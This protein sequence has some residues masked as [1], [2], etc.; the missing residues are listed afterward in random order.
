MVY[1][2]FEKKVE[3]QSK[4]SIFVHYNNKEQVKKAVYFKNCTA[5]LLF[6][7]IALVISK[8]LQI[9]SL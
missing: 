6:N 4:I 7:W 5:L 1:F 3:H 2:S 8:N 9:F